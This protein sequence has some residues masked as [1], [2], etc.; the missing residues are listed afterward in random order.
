MQNLLGE[1]KGEARGGVGGGGVKNLF[2]WRMTFW[3]VI[4]GTFE[5]MP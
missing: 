5:T 3:T 2:V 4:V 1:G